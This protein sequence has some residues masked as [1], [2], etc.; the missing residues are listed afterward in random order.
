MDKFWVLDTEDSGM[1]EVYWYNFYNGKQH[2]A[3]DKQE[4]ALNFLIGVKGIIWC[5][6]LEYDILNLFKNRMSSLKIVYGQRMLWVTYKYNKDIKFYDTLNHWIDVSV[7]KMGKFLNYPKGKFNP[8]N[9]RYCQKDCEITYKF[10]L[11]M[12]TAY[13][14]LG[15]KNIN[16]T[17]ASTSFRFWYDFFRPISMGFIEKKYLDYF[18]LFYFGARTENF[19]LGKFKNV[20]Y[21]DVN[22]M[23]PFMMLNRYPY[24]FN[25]KI[26]KCISSKF[27]LI[28]AIVKSNLEIPILPVKSKRLLFPNGIFQVYSNNVEFENFLELGG[29]IKKINKVVNFSTGCFPFRDYVKFLYPI[30][31]TADDEFIKQSA[32]YLLNT[33]YGKFAQYRDYNEFIGI[34]D[35]I[36]KKKK[37]KGEIFGDI[38]KFSSEKKKYP[39]FTNFIFSIFI[40]AYARN[41]LYNHILMLN[42]LK[43]K[44]LYTDTDSIFYIGDLIHKKTD[45]IGDFSLKNV[46]DE[47]YFK[48]LKY[49][50]V[51]D[52]GEWLYT[53]KGIRKE[54]R[55][56]FFEKGS[57]KFKR[58]VKFRES[59]RVKAYNGKENYWLEFEKTDNR[60][61]DKGIVFNN[62]IYPFI[63]NQQLEILNKEKKL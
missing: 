13:S 17:I 63:V 48:G 5:V 55:K 57:C 61:Y 22:S 59:K 9:L 40:T 15:I 10:I 51:K 34:D 30:K 31:Q 11:K 58:P 45:K 38:I 3:F 28:D 8:K 21:I 23:Y 53:I 37:I 62:K 35:F 32:K 36:D 33:L 16:P 29:K 60:K 43:K 14:D 26:S 7:E 54:A 42:S 50:K 52:N 39:Y 20:N 56:D 47:V 24:P 18:R 12:I 2:F 4:K 49:Y 46:Y 27:Y 19:Y 41:Y 25:F 6:N 1:G 44:V